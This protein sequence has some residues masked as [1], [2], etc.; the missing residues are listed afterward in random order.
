MLMRGRFA[1]EC[2]Y[3]QQQIDD[4]EM[5]DVWKMARYW[6]LEPPVAMLLAMKFGYKSEPESDPVV[7]TPH[8][9]TPFEKLAPWLQR[10]LVK[11]SG[12]TEAEYRRALKEK[13]T[14]EYMKQLAELRAKNAGRT[15][16]TDHG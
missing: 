11:R 12:K 16:T 8:N 14:A 10:S 2:H 4:L 1:T 13:R 5:P 6:K 7:V 15:T 9:I 3:T